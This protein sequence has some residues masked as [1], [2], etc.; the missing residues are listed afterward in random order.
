M[1]SMAVIIG[2]MICIKLNVILVILFIVEL[3][4]SLPKYGMGRN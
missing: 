2:W 4:M 3:I 1:K